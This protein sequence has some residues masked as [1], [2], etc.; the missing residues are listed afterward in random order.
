MAGTQFVAHPFGPLWDARSRVLILGTMPSPASR[1]ASFYYAHPQNR[2]W[3]ALCAALGERDP[4]DN[5][6][7]RALAL[8]RRIALWDVLARCEI[9][10]ASDASIRGAVP[11]DLT[12]I[13]AGADIAAIFTTGKKSY[14]LYK[15][16]IEPITGRPAVCLPSPSPANCAVHFDAL[17]AAYGA[18]AAALAAE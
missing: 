9:A 10:G 8:R 12:P 6:A 16:Y 2:F 15:K 1:R 4:G 5:A 18:V 14:E 13:L 3:P 17:V 11:N 7:R